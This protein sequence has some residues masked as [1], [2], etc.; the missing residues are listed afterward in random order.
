MK[1]NRMIIAIDAHRDGNPER[2][3]IG[4]IPHIPGETLLDKLRDVRNGLHHLRTMLVHEA[5]GHSNTQA[6]LLVPPA[7]DE[8]DY[9]VV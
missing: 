7:S 6:A 4:G 9:G 5:G 2:V 8:A 1:F 3:V